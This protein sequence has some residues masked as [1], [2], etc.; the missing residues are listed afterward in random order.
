MAGQNEL[1]DLLIAKSLSR[2]LELAGGEG[3]PCI[4]PEIMPAIVLESD[5]PETS[6]LK[7]EYLG[8][9]ALAATA[10]AATNYAAIQLSLA[11]AVRTLTTVT[12]IHIQLL[13]AG[14]VIIG[15]GTTQSGIAVPTYA[16]DSRRGTI[17]LQTKAHTG[18]LSGVSLIGQPFARFVSAAATQ[19]T[20]EQPIVLHPG[21]FL[22]VQ[23]SID[24]VALGVV[25][26]AFRERPIND[27]ERP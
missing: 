21:N 2:R 26:F 14:D 19:I 23:S 11:A 7:Q 6:W 1:G 24:A 18:S 16:R 15:F 5:R 27:A 25:S 13:A 12:A 22:T 4:A 10:P 17:S 8:G 20:F 3:A 9:V